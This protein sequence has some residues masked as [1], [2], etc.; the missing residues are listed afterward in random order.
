VLFTAD[1]PYSAGRSIAETPPGLYRATVEI[2]GHLLIP[3]HYYVDLGADYPNDKGVLSADR[4][5][6]FTIVATGTADVPSEAIYGLVYP[7]LPWRTERVRED[8]AMLS[9]EQRRQTVQV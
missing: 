2:P 7:E 6:S 1:K 9:K 4:C 3:G 5:L 8:P